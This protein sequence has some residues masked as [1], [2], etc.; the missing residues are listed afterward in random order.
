MLY[1]FD[2]LAAGLWAMLI[3]AEAVSV[4]ATPPL[5]AFENSDEQMEDVALGEFTQAVRIF[6][7][8]LIVAWGTV[9]VFAGFVVS[10]VPVEIEARLAAFAK[11]F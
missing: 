11:A 9:A 4:G 8:V 7:N 6:A 3:A 2:T 5:V 1:R 10:A